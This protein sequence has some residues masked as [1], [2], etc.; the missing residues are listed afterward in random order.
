MK[1]KWA[2]VLFKPVIWSFS[3]TF[4]TTGRC[5]FISIYNM[6]SDPHWGLSKEVMLGLIYPRIEWGVKCFQAKGKSPF[7]GAWSGKELCMLKG[8]EERP[9]WLG[10][11][12]QGG[13]W[14]KMRSER[15]PHRTSEAVKA[16][17]LY[18]KVTGSNWRGFQRKVTGLD[19]LSPWLMVPSI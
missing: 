11:G 1:E 7:A 19:L 14:H 8:G 10:Q 15:W 6:E 18:P 4:I 12:K 5:G 17:G 3:V 16:F 2:L 9:G 13:K